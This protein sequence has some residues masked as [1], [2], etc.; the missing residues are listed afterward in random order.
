MQKSERTCKECYKYKIAGLPSSD[1]DNH[2]V[3]DNVS[4]CG[5]RYI[6]K[7]LALQ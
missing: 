6:V 5:S 1:V 4:K 7:S 3:G 2:V